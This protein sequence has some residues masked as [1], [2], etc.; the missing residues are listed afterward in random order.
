MPAVV[1]PATAEPDMPEN[2]NGEAADDDDAGFVVD[3]K[4]VRVKSVV[5]T[6][7]VEAAVAVDAP[8]FD[9][10]LK[11]KPIGLAA[12]AVAAVGTVAFLLSPKIK[13]GPVVVV[14]LLFAVELPNK[15][16]ELL[17]APNGAA[18]VVVVVL[19]LP[20]KIV[21]L[22]VSVLLVV[23]EAENWAAENVKL[24]FDCWFSS[25][26]LL[27]VSVVPNKLVDVELKRP[28]GCFD[29]EVVVVVFVTGWFELAV[30]PN[31]NR[32]VPPPPLF[33][34]VSAVC[35]WG[36][37]WF[38]LLLVLNGFAT[39]NVG[40]EED[41]NKLVV[42]EVVLCDGWGW[43]EDEPPNMSLFVCSAAGLTGV[44]SPA[45]PNSNGLLAADVGSSLPNENPPV[46]PLTAGL[47]EKSEPPLLPELLLLVPNVIPPLVLDDDEKANVFLSLSA[48]WVL[49][50]GL[51]VM[52]QA[53]SLLLLSF[54]TKHV[55][56]SHLA[57]VLVVLNKD[58]DEEV[59]ANRDDDD[60]DVGWLVAAAGFWLLASGCCLP[61]EKP[62]PI[63]VVS[64]LSLAVNEL[65]PK[66]MGACC[67]LL[68][69]DDCEPNF[70]P[71]DDSL[72]AESRS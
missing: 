4:G 64:E 11:L 65:V 10:K 36:L 42:V 67:C 15:N 12:S 54:L 66:L 51:L 69:L 45:V 30:K 14:W 70:I 21:D 37:L 41:L 48:A 6:V 27:V 50:L 60:V 46:S 5:G 56:H 40:C 2:I 52:Q 32:D 63:V 72:L 29:S 31:L 57:A 68:S 61:K 3:L 7:P 35:C 53:H 16:G 59:G 23:V 1:V 22:L 39:L 38:S 47:V 43:V 33:A 17:V 58:E 62:Q 9:W 55:E 44:E 49:V 8:E 20:N 71:I 26:L 18:V 24:T 34:V 28:V 13:E 19:D 25:G